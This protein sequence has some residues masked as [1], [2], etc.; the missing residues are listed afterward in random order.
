MFTCKSKRV[1]GFVILQSSHKI[2]HFF[3]CYMLNQL[4]L[5]LMDS[6]DMV[7][8]YINL[9]FIILVK[10]TIL[11]GS[12]QLMEVRIPSLANICTSLTGLSINI[13][14]LRL[15]RYLLSFLRLT[16][17]KKDLDSFWLRCGTWLYWFLIFA[18]LLTFILAPWTG[19]FTSLLPLTFVMLSQYMTFLPFPSFQSTVSH[20]LVDFLWPWLLVKFFYLDVWSILW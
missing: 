12:S 4:T 11:W 5:Y 17:L 14:V 7:Y 13:K 3:L 15:D 19:R 10:A 1:H 6:N 16:S 9:H 2:D 18:P 20:R 8:I